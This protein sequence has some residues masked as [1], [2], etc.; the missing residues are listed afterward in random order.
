MG[1]GFD[2]PRHSYIFLTYGMRMMSEKRLIKYLLFLLF[3]G[4]PLAIMFGRSYGYFIF[5]AY[6]EPKLVHIQLFS[7][8]LIA[9]FW[10]AYVFRH[11]D[12]MRIKA[13]VKDRYFLL[14]LC[15]V[16]FLSLT[17]VNSLVPSASF[18]EL[19]QY[20]TLINLYVVLTFLWQEDGFFEVSLLG[21]VLGLAVATFIG[22]YQYF[23][24]Q[25]PF[26]MPISRYHFFASTFGNKNPMALAVCAQ[27]YLA[28]L[29][30]NSVRAIRHGWVIIGVGAVV[31]LAEFFY[32]VMLGSRTSYGA[33]ALSILF[34][35][36]C[37]VLLAILKRRFKPL[38][39][40]VMFTLFGLLAAYGAISVNKAAQARVQRT[41]FFI[42]RPA[43]YLNTARGVCLRNSVHMANSRVLGVGIGNWGIAYPFYRKVKYPR[44]FNKRV[45]IRRAHN[46]Y[47]QML[48][49][50]GWMGLMLFL[51]VLF[52]PLLRGMRVAFRDDSGEMF[53]L[54]SQ[55]VAFLFLMLTDFC[56]EMPYH[57]FFLF[58]ILAAIQARHFRWSNSAIAG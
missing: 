42:K 14:I 58:T 54:T 1:F 10:F 53:L 50:T 11:E 36:G 37:F 19:I 49:E 24:G 8:L 2:F 47:A 38:F 48:G 5:T 15:F 34:S 6:R 16:A 3:F 22:L 55:L 31:L 40:A 13:I 32:L 41:I 23:L 21:V 39:F 20:F 18:Y 17:T 35:L 30:F 45:Q 4:A 9:M 25:I 12:V 52:W 51:C 29:W 57:K 33:V 56:I 26:L 44:I 27:L 43:E 46:D 7:W 28:I